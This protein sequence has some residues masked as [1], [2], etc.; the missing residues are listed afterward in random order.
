MS[1]GS[2]P[3]ISV[4]IPTYNRAHVLPRAIRS[5]LAQDI[6]D[7]EV[8]VVDDGSTD[9]TAQVLTELDDARLV[10]V[11]QPSN[12]GVAVA[13]NAGVLAGSA[14]FVT[15]LDSDDEAA[16]GWLS[17]FVDARRSG[18]DLVFCGANFVGPGTAHKLL[19]PERQGPEMGGIRGLY[20]AGT[21]AIDK[22][23]FHRVGGFRPG[24][25]FSENTDLG[26]RIGGHHL[27]QQLT[28]GCVERP[29]ITIHRQERPY[30]PSLRY[31][32]AM[33]LLEHDHEHLRR[34]PQALST[35]LAVAGVAAARLG[36]RREARQ[37]LRRAIAENPRSP[38]HYGRL[39]RALL[40]LASADEP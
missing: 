29:L 21:Y 17:A 10:S 14:G 1:T 4:V 9:E 3:E 18:C 26:L 31:E 2:V 13:R 11:V 6:T 16:P 5:V 12:C 22:V 37:L 15:F 7:L 33:V 8:V 27:Q 40:P 20:L 38:K 19:L 30:Q 23:L 25:R 24:L 28:I 34:N 36:R 35:Y 39:L 32:S